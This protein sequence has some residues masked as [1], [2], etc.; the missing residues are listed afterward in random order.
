M[1]ANS[2]TLSTKADNTRVLALSL[3]VFLFTVTSYWNV[4]PWDMSALYFAASFYSEGQFDQVFPLGPEFLWDEEDVPSTWWALAEREQGAF[5]EPPLFITPYVYPPLWAAALAPIAGAVS[6]KVF[7]VATITGFAASLA[8]ML[9]LGHRLVASTMPRSRWVAI[10]LPFAVTGAATQIAL[11]FGQPQVIISLMVLQS[12]TWS[13]E[14]KPARAG[15]LLALAAAIKLSPALF[16]MIFIMDRNWRALG[17]FAGVGGGLAALSVA[18]TGWELHEH[19]LAQIAL[20]DGQILISRINL[21]LNM[22]LFEFQNLISGNF[23]WFYRNPEFVAEPAHIG[24]I[25]RGVLL[26]S[27]FAIYFA[28]RRA[29]RHKRTWLRLMLVS[30]IYLFLTPL[31]WLHYLVL[32]IMLLPGLLEYSR[33]RWMVLLLCVL[34][35]FLS[36]PVYY[37]LVHIDAS[38]VFQVFM[39]VGCVLALLCAVLF[40]ARTPETAAPTQE[41]EVAK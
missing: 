18:V 1:S 16:A 24:V 8:W 25:V 37:L 41:L 40:V 2:P 9:S 10:L 27:P 19:F 4:W 23:N 26:A 17:W 22:V 32:P 3:L 21:S 15:A 6:L 29:E 34:G 11:N 5:E 33:S 36:F 13:L 30:M 35:V 39:H 7:W 31:G 38:F 12:F 20:L 14:G 28:T